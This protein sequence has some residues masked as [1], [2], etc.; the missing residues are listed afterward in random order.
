MKTIGQRQRGRQAIVEGRSHV[1]PFRDDCDGPRT[2]RDSRVIFSS[3]ACRGSVCVIQ[4]F[5]LAKR[6]MLFLSSGQQAH[7]IHPI[8]DFR[9][10]RAL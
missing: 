10:T 7:R 9:K 4:L 1:A 5:A 6:G 8:Y 3:R 2:R